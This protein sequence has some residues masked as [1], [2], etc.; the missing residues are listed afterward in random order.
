MPLFYRSFYQRGWLALAWVGLLA[1]G[2]ARR[3]YFLPDSRVGATATAPLPATTDSVR[4]AAGRH[5]SQHSDLYYLFLGRHYR[6]VWA[7]PVT[8]PVLRLATVVPGG[9]RPGK[10]GGGFQS[11]S[12]TLEGKQDREYALRALDK[13]PAKTLPKVLR[14]TFLLNV[15][16]DATS[17]ANPYAALTVPPLARAAGVPHTRPQL[18]YVRPDE[19]GLGPG[20]ERFQGKVALLEEKYEELAS[21]TPDLAGATNFVG[22]ETVLKKTYYQPAGYLDQPAFLRARLLDLLLGDW[23]RHERQW[24]WA[25]FPEANSRTRYQPIPKDRDQVYF[26]F[27][28]GLVPWLASRRFIAPQ[29]HTF[30][31]SY[32]YLPGLIYQA[33]FIDRRGLSQLKRADFQRIAADLQRR[34]PDSVIERAMRRLPPAVFALEGARLGGALK[35]RRQHLPRA[36]DEFYQLLAR[37]PNLG[38]SAQA[39]RFVVRRFADSTTVQVF[40]SARHAPTTADTLRFRRTYFTAE[41][42][43]L[44]LDGL[45]GDDI[46][47]VTT[48]GGGRPIRLRLYGGTGQDQLLRQG[49]ARHLRLYPDEASDLTAA[50]SER[51]YLSRRRH[52]PAERTAEN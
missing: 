21:R 6:P 39:E 9:L 36:A 16:R 33:E 28:D 18:V 29:F 35:T 47:D 49:N 12:M 14:A 41:T 30:R 20:S 52:T 38:G 25:A 40:S 45:D 8:V 48:T 50:Q 7:A 32:G 51:P 37:E 3:N 27:D 2:C 26:R 23:D 31:A 17:A 42:R 24:D 34:L 43:T 13:D 44:L 11:I 10:A 22:G 4:V 15:V 19:T 5:Y 46:F 1:G